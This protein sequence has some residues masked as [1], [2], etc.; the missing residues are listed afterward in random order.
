MADKPD[1]PQSQVADACI[2][3]SDAIIARKSLMTVDEARKVGRDLFTWFSDEG[4]VTATKA[5]IAVRCTQSGTALIKDK[6]PV[7]VDDVVA[8]IKEDYEHYAP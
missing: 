4:A 8:G 7:T 6:R 1:T 3:L 5:P 2:S